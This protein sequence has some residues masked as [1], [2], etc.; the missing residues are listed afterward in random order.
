[1][2]IRPSERA[3]YPKDW[4]AITAR[5]RERAGNKCECIGQCGDSHCAPRGL[6]GVPNGASIARLRENPAV[7]L[8][9]PEIERGE[10][11]LD[12]YLDP[13]RVVLTVAHIDHAPEHNDPS[14][15]L[16]LCQRCHLKMDTKHH[17]KNAR[18]TRFSRKAVGE[19]FAALEASK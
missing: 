15:L 13:I 10:I 1:M 12:D 7:W 3:R 9:M 19:L 6:C 5:I 2:P 17:A 14:N 8:D 4:P 16:A 11:D 18:A